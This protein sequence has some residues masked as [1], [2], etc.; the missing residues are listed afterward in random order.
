MSTERKKPFQFLAK[1]VINLFVADIFQLHKYQVL[2]FVN[3]PI[4][5]KR[6]QGSGKFRIWKVLIVKWRSFQFSMKFEKNLSS[7]HLKEIYPSIFSKIL[8]V[9]N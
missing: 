2:P 7:L 5:R 4:T 9:Q 6:Q 3:V 8:V 1:L